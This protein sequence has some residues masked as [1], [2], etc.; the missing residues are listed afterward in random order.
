VLLAALVTLFMTAGPLGV[1]QQAFPPVEELTIHRIALPR[2]GMM[3]VDVVNGGPAPVTVAQV[4]VDDASW[5]HSMDGPRT[6]GRLETRRLEVPYPWVEGEPHTI[7]LVTS[8]GLTF[9]TTVDVAVQTPRADA[10]YLSTFALLGVY[11][12]VIPVLIGLLWL[13]F[14]RAWPW[15]LP[16]AWRQLRTRRAPR[17]FVPLAWSALV[18]LFF[19]LS[20]GKR[21]MYILPALPM[22]CVALAPGLVVAARRR[23]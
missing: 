22:L 21:D 2:A 17:V 5:V 11:A 3:E 19:S 23:G 16:F 8:T 10:R 13:P 1:F 15:A 18:L 12:G 7:T 20:P 6:I 9:S 14:V 4:F